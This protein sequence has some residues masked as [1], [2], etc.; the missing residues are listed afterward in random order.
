MNSILSN[1][2]PYIE[3]NFKK[4]F[5]N[6]DLYKHLEN[7]YDMLVWDKLYS[8]IDHTE[9]TPR[10]VYELRISY[11]S[12]F[13]YILPLL[14]KNPESIAD[15]GCGINPFK[16]FIPNLVGYN[17][18][19]EQADL[20]ERFSETFI[21]KYQHKF[22]AAMSINSLH[23]ISIDTFSQRIMDFSKI[24]KPNGRG[25]ITFNLMQ[26]L[27]DDG[28]NR[29]DKIQKIFG[30]VRPNNLQVENYLRQETESLDL[31]ILIWDLDFSKTAEPINGNIRLV[32]ET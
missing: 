10:G 15:I 13:Y 3:Q 8:S 31:N 24:I 12:I 23:F 18:T 21:K 14:E 7:Y 26:L 29:L 25:L 4:E 27:H 28:T 22:D 2:N 9:V 17:P 11:C 19:Y 20:I 32:F 1:I 16:R 6:T 5:K 30:T